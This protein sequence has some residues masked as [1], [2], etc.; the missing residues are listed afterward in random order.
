MTQTIK[1]VLPIDAY[2]SDEQVTIYH[3]DCLDVMRGMEDGS[4]DAIVTDPPYGIGFVSAWRTRKEDRNKAVINDEAPYVEWIPDAFRVLK[5]GGALACFYRWDVQDQFVAAFKSAGFT[6]KSQ[7]VWH[8][9]GGGIGDLNAA[10]APEHE[11][12]LFVVKGQFSFAHGRPMSVVKVPR[13]RPENL[14]HPC[15]K[16][17]DLIGHLIR[18]IS[19]V[20]SIVFDPFGGSGATGKAAKDNGRRAVLCDLDADYCA[21]AAGR[22]SQGVLM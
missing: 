13:V 18:H 20:G 19:N 7:V 9:G 22:L 14:T 3:A 11:L 12:L 1:E 10:F 4:V 2:Y 16:P 21:I 8:K 17:T 6:V 5:D 15:E